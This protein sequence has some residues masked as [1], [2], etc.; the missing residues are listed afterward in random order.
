MNPSLRQQ[1]SY[2]GLLAGAQAR[3]RVRGGAGHPAYV[4]GQAGAVA[5]PG[6]KA[7]LGQ[8]V[9]V[10]GHGGA[11]ARALLQLPVVAGGVLGAHQGT[12]APVGD[13]SGHLGV[14]GVRKL[15]PQC[16]AVQLRTN[17]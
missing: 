3:V 12:V 8:V 15:P 17:Y 14:T 1:G 9:V 13:T 7:G 11:L 2:C 4:L 16:R 6:D 10:G 5:V